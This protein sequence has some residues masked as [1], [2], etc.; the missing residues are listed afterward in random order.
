MKTTHAF[1]DLVRAMGLVLLATR[2][3]G[4]AAATPATAPPT[5]CEPDGTLQFVCGPKNAEDIVRLGTTR[6]LITSGMDGGLTASQSANGR[7]YLVDH[8][9]K[10]WR[11]AFPGSAPA[12]RHDRNLFGSCPG[13]IDTK[14]FSAHGLALRA[15]QNGHHR[16]YVTGH[17]AREAIEVFDVDAN[18]T[19]PTISW[20]G[21][22]LLPE[23]VSAN[24]VAIL[25]DW[26][27]VTTKFLDRRLPQ[28]ES[29]AQVRQGQVNGAVYEWHPGSQV[30]LVAGTELSAPNGIEVSPDGNTIFVAVFGSRELVRFRRGAGGLQKDSIRLGITPDNIRWSTN[31]KLLTAGG[32]EVA[33]GAATGTGWSVIEVDPVTLASR[34]V[35]GG[36]SSKG[37]QAISV[38]TDVGDEIWVGTF[39]GDRIGYQKVR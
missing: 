3:G 17:G 38:G 27:F 18:G 2:P 35:A 7:L 13:P 12:L 28:Q 14:N 10:S 32:D 16:L 11:E 22:V 4:A 23:D 9:E 21:C 31:G 6:W 37:M 30:R 5:G 24:S 15:Q 8:R 29:F 34:R 19:T 1:V 26:G 20:I 36:A 39:N 25:P 33:P